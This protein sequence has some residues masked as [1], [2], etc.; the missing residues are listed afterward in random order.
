M[1][2]TW[3]QLF[4]ICASRYQNLRS[5]CNATY[6]VADVRTILR[7][8]FAHSSEIPPMVVAVEQ[9]I[10]LQMQPQLSVPSSR[11][12]VHVQRLHRGIACTVQLACC[13]I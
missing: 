9:L 4:M 11:Q 7:R 2:A 1:P 10:C 6:L 12:M 5:T 3:S 8:V 13:S